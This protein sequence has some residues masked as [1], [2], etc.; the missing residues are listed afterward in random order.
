MKILGLI[1]GSVVL[2]VSHT[3]L[4]L[5]A[6]RSDVLDAIAANV[7]EYMQS[8]TQI[9]DNI[10]N[11]DL[12][13]SDDRVIGRISHDKS[14]F[15]QAT[16]MALIN[17]YKDTLVPH[18]CY[19]TISE[20]LACIMD[21][22]EKNEKFFIEFRP[23]RLSQGLSDMENSSQLVTEVRLYPDNIGDT[24]LNAGVYEKFKEMFV[25]NQVPILNHE[26][27]KED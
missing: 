4:C 1:L 22:F 5:S 12:E 20:S 9:L 25:Q 18:G 13:T 11:R 6:D 7:A 3:K 23:C 26:F 21:Q 15:A 8:E 19:V 24:E 17:R 2:F 27:P 16:F 14:H 10:N